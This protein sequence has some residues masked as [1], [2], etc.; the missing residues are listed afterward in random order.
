MKLEEAIKIRKKEYKPYIEYLL[1]KY[2]YKDWNIVK[3]NSDEYCQLIPVINENFTQIS[4][5]GVYD[6]FFITNDTAFWIEF[7]LRDIFLI[8]KIKKL[9]KQCINKE[10]LLKGEE[11]AKIIIDNI[12]SIPNNFKRAQKI[13]NIL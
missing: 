2:P 5:D 7:S 4:I 13:K 10:E 3:H 1:K 6:I 8:R 11:K 9:F 12:N